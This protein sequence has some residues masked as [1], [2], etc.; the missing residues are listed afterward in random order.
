MP[1]AADPRRFL[2]RFWQ[3]TLIGTPAVFIRA[4]LRASTKAQDAGRALAALEQFAADRGHAIAARYQENASGTHADRPELRRLLGDARADDVLLVEAVDRLSRLPAHDWRQ[5]RSEIEAKQ[6]RIVA[7]DLPT[8]HVGMT[9]I[10][11]DEF[12]GRMLAAI[13][14]MMLDMLAAIARKDYDDRRHRQDQGITK[15]KAAGK[16]QGGTRNRNKRQRVADALAAGFSIR[17]AAA[18][19]GVSPTTA[20][21]VKK[22]GV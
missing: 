7:L 4:Y 16:Y 19:V 17:R 2:V 15:A 5:L 11:G 14:S 6:L 20:Q 9:D 8:S 18:L 10:T 12:T 21:S 22:H 1:V 13:N 3:Y